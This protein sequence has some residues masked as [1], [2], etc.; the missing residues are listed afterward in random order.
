VDIDV[1]VLFI[2]LLERLCKQLGK[3][4]SSSQAVASYFDA[5]LSV[6]PAAYKKSWP[7]HQQLN[8]A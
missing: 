2:D 8:Q 3:I 7:V 4:H 5:F 1:P 6:L